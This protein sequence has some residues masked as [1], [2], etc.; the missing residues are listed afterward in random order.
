[1]S[2]STI[3]AATHGG[4]SISTNGGTAFTNHTTADGLGDDTVNGVYVSGQIIYAAT[5]GGTAFTNYTT[6]NGLG[7]DIVNG[8]YVQ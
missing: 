4:L 3:Y 6:A 2:G 8:V 1:V 7:D 5:N